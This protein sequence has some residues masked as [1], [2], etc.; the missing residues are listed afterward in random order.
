M[1][2]LGKSCTDIGVRVVIDEPSDVT[3]F[4]HNKIVNGRICITLQFHT[5]GLDLLGLHSSD[6]WFACM[7]AGAATCGVRTPL[8]VLDLSQVPSFFFSPPRTTPL[9]SLAAAFFI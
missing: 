9:L 2:A 6:A 3:D 1:L 8:A 5:L 7:Y 4:Y